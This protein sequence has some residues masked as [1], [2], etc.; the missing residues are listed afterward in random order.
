MSSRTGATAAHSNDTVKNNIPLAIVLNSPGG[1]AATVCVCSKQAAIRRWRC[2]DSIARKSNPQ[3][4]SGCGATCSKQQCSE[5]RNKLLH[6]L[7]RKTKRQPQRTC[8]QQHVLTLHPTRHGPECI[9]KNTEDRRHKN[10]VSESR[11]DNHLKSTRQVT[12][13][14]RRRVPL[15]L[16]A[17]RFGPRL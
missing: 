1:W 15:N 9:S 17:H 4:G 12:T 13:E 14:K 3:S 7:H 10:Q 2:S 8:L 5:V 11:T 6:M 16:H